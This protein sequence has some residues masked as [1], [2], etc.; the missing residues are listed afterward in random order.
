MDEP[1][2]IWTW[3]EGVL[4]V[5]RPDFLATQR[6]IRELPEVPEPESPERDDNLRDLGPNL[7]TPCAGSRNGSSCSSTKTRAATAEP[8]D[9]RRRTAWPDSLESL[10]TACE[11]RTISTPAAG[12]SNPSGPTHEEVTRWQTKRRG[13]T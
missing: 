7:R 12:W 9:R 10:V 4:P 3:R 11:Q 1:D 5:P 2:D 13:S 6:E 8:P